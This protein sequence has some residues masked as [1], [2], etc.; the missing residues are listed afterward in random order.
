MTLYSL[1]FDA[2][3]EADVFGGVRRSVEAAQ[4]GQEAVRWQ[5]RDGEVTL[6]AEIATAY[7]GLRAAQAR[8]GILAGELKS[9]DA[10][11]DLVSARGAHRI[12]HRAG[13]EPAICAEGEYAGTDTCAG[14]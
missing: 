11:L 2:T 1:G 14:S 10:T 6:T 12:C 4:A 3:W 7:I 9:Q 5:M 8:L 13:C